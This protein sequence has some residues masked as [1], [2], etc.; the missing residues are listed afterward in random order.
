MVIDPFCG[1]GTVAV[2]AK[3][4]GRDFAGSEFN[5]AY[6]EMALKRL[7]TTPEPTD[8]QA[9][10]TEESNMTFAEVEA[11]RRQ[12]DGV[13]PRPVPK[14][15]KR[16]KPEAEP[17]WCPNTELS[18]AETA[19]ILTPEMREAS[20]QRMIKYNEER[21]GQ[22]DENTGRAGLDSLEA[23]GPDTERSGL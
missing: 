21:R 23:L 6:V 7:R 14:P 19:Q 11:L 1:A 18:D 20:Q 8:F 16:P 9:G 2:V 13:K 5:P 17:K 4:L 10:V 15:P 12:I 3:Q 22:A